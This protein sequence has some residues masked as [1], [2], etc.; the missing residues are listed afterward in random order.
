[1][2]VRVLFWKYRTKNNKKEYITYLKI[3]S[4]TIKQYIYQLFNKII[5]F[6]QFTFQFVYFNLTHIF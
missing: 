6:F 1:M 5:C 2:K 4:Y 3:I